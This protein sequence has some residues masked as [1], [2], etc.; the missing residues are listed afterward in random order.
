M[1]QNSTEFVFLDLEHFGNSGAFVTREY[2]DF[3][4]IFYSAKETAINFGDFYSEIGKEGQD[5]IDV[6]FEGED[7]PSDD[8]LLAD[9]K[10]ELYI[11][12]DDDFPL[13]Q[14]LEET[15]TYYSSL[16]PTH[17]CQDKIR[18]EYGEYIGLYSLS[19][20]DLIKSHLEENRCSVL[21]LVQ[22]SQ[23]G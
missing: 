19:D 8:E 2:H 1:Q 10:S 3:L 4:K 6:F 13:V 9:L 15:Y 7:K 12:N 17:L 14:C 23:Y 22:I 16:F 20:Y 5:F 11:F 18:T 21:D